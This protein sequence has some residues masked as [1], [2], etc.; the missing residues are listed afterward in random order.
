MK[1]L[2]IGTKIDK[3]SR[4][5]MMNMIDL[6]GFN[7]SSIDTELFDEKDLDLEKIK[8]YD[9]VIFVSK[10]KSKKKEKIL[11][12]HAPGNWR[13]VWGGG[14]E[15]KVCFSSGIFQ[16]YLFE[17]LENKRK[18]SNLD[19]YKVTM[20]VTH[21][22]PL[23]D[24]PCLFIEIGGGEE[25][26]ADRRASF[27]ISRAVKEAIE[28]FKPS[29]YLEVAIG[30]GGPHYCPSFNKLQMN[31]NVAFSHIIPKYIFPITEEMIL[32]A[33]KKTVEEV[34]FVVVDWKGLGVAE[35]RNRI[36]RILEK[37]YIRWKKTSEIK[38]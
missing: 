16:K 26:W 17:V 27:V 21:H 33:I 4:N 15:G 24:K 36:I 20:E 37:N 8:A 22:G 13:D 30:I 29:K 9:F 28:T 3:A 18:E 12:I 34:E 1:F 38:K 31:S 6:G 25:E 2:I 35:E 23:I 19:K 11:S 7:I 10:H 32:E 14:K 5:I